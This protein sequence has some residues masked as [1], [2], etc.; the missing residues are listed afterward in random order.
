LYTFFWVIPRHLNFI[1]RRFRTLCLFHLH[2]R[3]GV[4]LSAYEDGTDRVFRNV[5]I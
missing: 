1:C 3:I 2:R 5:S 4:R